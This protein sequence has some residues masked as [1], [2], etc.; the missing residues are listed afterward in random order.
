MNKELEDRLK[1]KALEALM[2]LVTDITGEL[3]EL[4]RSGDHV[5]LYL[6]GDLLEGFSIYADSPG[7]VLF[8]AMR[9][10]MRQESR[11]L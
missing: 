10:I 6:N 11:I 7:A 5:A 2:A 4:R 8:D 1:T 9:G 3:I